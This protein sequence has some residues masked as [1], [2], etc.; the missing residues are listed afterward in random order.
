MAWTNNSGLTRSAWWASRRAIAAGAL[1]MSAACSTDKILTVTD[2]D[3]APSSYL[4][5][6]AALPIVLGGALASFHAA[7]VGHLPDA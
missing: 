4:N 2:P 6:T 5:S 1:I 3:V 7:F